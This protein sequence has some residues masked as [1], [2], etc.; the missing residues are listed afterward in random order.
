LPDRA[1][2]LRRPDSGLPRGHEH[3][4]SVTEGSRHPASPVLP[5]NIGAKIETSPTERS[6][7]ERR[8]V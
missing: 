2:A 8:Y 4:A 3:V 1:T 6:R 5:G 7:R